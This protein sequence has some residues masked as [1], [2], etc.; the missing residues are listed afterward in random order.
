MNII[1]YIRKE[2]NINEKRVPIIPY[3]IPILI[4]NNFIIYIQSS[5]NRIYSDTEY[6]ENGAIITNLPWYNEKFKD[7]LIIGFKE[8]NDLTKL[9]HHLHIYFAHCYKK[10]NNSSIILNAFKSSNSIL[11]DFEYF[12]NYNKIFNIENK[13]QRIISFGVYAGI[14]GSAIGLMQ[15]YNYFNEKKDIKNLE[16]YDEKDMLIFDLQNNFKNILIPKIVIIGPGGNCGKGVQYI[17]Q[18][19][20]LKYDILLST[21][22]IN[23]DLLKNYDIIFNC[24]LL[25]EKYNSIWFN[26][27][28]IKI[29]DH[30]LL[31]VDISCDNEK[32]NNPI[33]LNYPNT[34]FKEPVF[35]LNNFV[36]IIAIANLPSYLPK[37]SSIYFSNKFIKLLL[38]Y[39]KNKENIDWK[40]NKEIFYKILDSI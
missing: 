1:I 9:D 22:T 23:F 10:Q 32:L 36:K 30:N 4:N 39:Q 35:E 33:R 24:I 31:I 7:A 18:L 25:D 40:K 2:L 15:Y 5:N 29:I 16:F 19:L 27:E 14:S 37:N 34:T 26:D 8:L 20:R 3:N 21:D 6:Q 38:N 11:Y 17:L 28:N 12:L 13:I